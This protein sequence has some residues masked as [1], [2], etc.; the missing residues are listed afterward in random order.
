MCNLWLMMVF[1]SRHL[2]FRRG[3]VPIARIP[4]TEHMRNAIR[5]VTDVWNRKGLLNSF[6]LGENM[7]RFVESSATPD[8]RA[9]LTEI[10]IAKEARSGYENTGSIW[11]V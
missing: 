7:V 6:C 4:M 11:H 3:T 10:E 8:E 1:L 9:S 5:S 2:A